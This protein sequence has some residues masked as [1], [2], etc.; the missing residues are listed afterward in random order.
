MND[1]CFQSLTTIETLL[2]TKQISVTDVVTAC[3]K[4]IEMV[5]PKISALL[6]I[7][8]DDALEKAHAMD[9][10]GPEKDKP[11]WGIPLV[12][13][14]A[15]STANLKTTAASKILEN[16]VPIYDA[17]VISKLKNAGAIILAKSNMDEFAMG[18]STEN[19][20]FKVTKNPWN[21]LK[22]PGGSSGGSAASVSSCQCFGSLGSDT[23]GSIRQPASF[24]GCVGLKPTYG[25]VSRYGLFAF[26]SSLDQIG[27][28]A[29]NVEDC[30][31]I[32]SAISGYDKKDNTSSPLPVDDYHKNFKESWLNGKIIGVPYNFFSKGISGE[33]Q[34]AS[35][36][37][38]KTIENLGG[39]LEE[40]ELP[41]PEIS[42]ATYYVI[43]TA[44]ASSNLAR[45][46]GVKYGFRSQDCKTLDELYIKSRSEGFGH[47]VK[48]RIMLGT[49]VLSSGYYDAYYKKAA[50]TRRMIFN[51]YRKI[52]QE[53]DALILPVAPVTAWDLG[54][55][56]S[57]PLQAYL[58]DAFT[59]PINLAGLPGIAIPVG[60]GEKTGMPVGLQLIGKDFDEANLLGMAFALEKNLPPIGLP[61]ILHN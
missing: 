42:I 27:P 44:E 36:I 8:Y 34:S 53:H 32:F 37:A 28:I 46:D 48:R 14:D 16:F 35:K 41:D 17:T 29:K 13:K 26:A 23:G 51:A 21:L 2:Q 33:V 11:L 1:I 58:M 61:P 10:N 45:Y 39:R 50:Q 18:S 22:V 52:L 15:I 24:C 56:S 25:R 6:A 47:E 40:V 59:L 20:A 5:E 49:Y 31:H 60:V 9:K 57:D 4:Q 30:A 12:I 3:L 43:A 38:L 19:S 54:F 55:H 7:N